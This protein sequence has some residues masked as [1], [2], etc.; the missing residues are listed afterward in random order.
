MN[1]FDKAGRYAVKH[2]PHE[3]RRWLFPDAPDSLR[4]GGW[5]DAQSA[6]RPGEPDRR[7]DTIMRLKYDEGP[8]WAA[9]F[10]IFTGH[11]ANALDRAGIAH[12]VAY[13][14]KHY[15]GQLAAV[16]AGLA[17]APFPRSSV[18]GDLKIFGEEAGLPPVGYF[19]IELHRAP[20]AKGP[21]FDALVSHIELNFGG[22]DA[23]AA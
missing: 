15:L 9:V 22:S 4:F 20:G 13:T 11:D 5:L 6:P 8:W 14:S 12:R 16:Q 1:D 10:E 7:C 3:T 23:A 21:A 2:G 19:E 18:S 17:I